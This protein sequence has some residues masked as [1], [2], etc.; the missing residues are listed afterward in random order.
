MGNKNANDRKVRGN[1][2]YVECVYQL[3]HTKRT[4][5]A[6]H[7]E[8]ETA[9]RKRSVTSGRLCIHVTIYV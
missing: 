7:R 4:I 2:L 5:K 9:S 3:K 1:S 6:H 8:K